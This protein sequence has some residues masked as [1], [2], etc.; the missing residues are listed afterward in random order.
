MR[1]RKRAGFTLIELMIVVSIVG[2]LAAIAIPNF[3]R[4]QQRTKSA[5]GPANVMAIRAAEITLSSARDRFLA[6]PVEP[7]ADDVLNEKKAPW[8]SEIEINAAADGWDQVG[9]RP[10]GA[11]YFNYQVN[12][13]HTIGGSF[14]VE[15]HADIDNDEVLQCML[16]RKTNTDGANSIAY[17]DAASCT[18]TGFAG[19]KLDV[20]YRSSAEG[21]F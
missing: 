3:T 9:W 20:P 5:E 6:V 12:V 16:F 18:D 1:D 4:Y 7:R 17:A 15:A 21:V 8:R 10:E 2:I 13:D 14:T 19:A 11:V